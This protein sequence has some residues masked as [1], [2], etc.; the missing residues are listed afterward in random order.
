MP[1]N[2]CPHA[3]GA[4]SGVVLTAPDP[5]SA[6]LTSGRGQRG[7]R[8]TSAIS[9]PDAPEPLRTSSSP[10]TPTEIPLS[11]PDTRSRLVVRASAAPLSAPNPA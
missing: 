3:L 7:Q 10:A 6:D 8:R 5:L 1:G 9:V 11:A 2:R 4:D